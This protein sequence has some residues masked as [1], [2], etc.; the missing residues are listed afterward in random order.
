MLNAVFQCFILKCL[1]LGLIKGFEFFNED[2]I[3]TWITMTL[4]FV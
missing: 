4:S 3:G 1:I 2:E